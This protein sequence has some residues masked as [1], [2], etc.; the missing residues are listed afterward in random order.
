M[1][2]KA[3]WRELAA[4]TFRVS[5]AQDRPG[6]GTAQPKERSVRLWIGPF[7]ASG[8]SIRLRVWAKGIFCRSEWPFVTPVG[9]FI[10]SGPLRTWQA[11]TYASRYCRRLRVSQ[12]H[13]NAHQGTKSR[14]GSSLNVL[15]PDEIVFRHA[16]AFGYAS[17][18]RGGCN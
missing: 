1:E 17:E 14:R 5:Q 3:R 9:I 15:L 2:P 7:R 4:R 6:Q 16:S 10:A 18:F 11:R 12:K 13:K 8:A